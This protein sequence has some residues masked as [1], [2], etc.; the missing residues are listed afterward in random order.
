MKGRLNC[1]CDV[2]AII[3]CNLSM[4]KQE[5]EQF[6]GNV[7]EILTAVSKHIVVWKVTSYSLLDKYVRRADGKFQLFLGL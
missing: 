3:L 5:A 2:T 4:L 7:F 6:F 1:S